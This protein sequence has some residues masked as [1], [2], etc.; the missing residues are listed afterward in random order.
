[1]RKLK[2]YD[3]VLAK[4]RHDEPQVLGK[5]VNIVPSCVL[6]YV[7]QTKRGSTV[8]CMRSELRYCPYRKPN[9]RRSPRAD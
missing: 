9:P 1:M 4:I 3:R 7:I 5:I 2:K 6:P 8:W